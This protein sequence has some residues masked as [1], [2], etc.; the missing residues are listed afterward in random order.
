L[1]PNQ[2]AKDHMAAVM[3]NYHVQPRLDYKTVSGVNGPLVILDNVKLPKY[4]EIVN[5]TL[6]SGEQRQ[7]QVL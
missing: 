1:D 5:I 4:A 3:K 6:G 2:A 7:G